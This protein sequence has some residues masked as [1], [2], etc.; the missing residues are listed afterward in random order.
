MRRLIRNFI[1]QCS[2]LEQ[3][4]ELFPFAEMNI[5]AWWAKIVAVGSYR[6]IILSPRKDYGQAFGTETCIIRP[7][8][9][10]NYVA[11]F[12]HLEWT[13]EEI[14]SLH[15]SAVLSQGSVIILLFSP[16]FL[17]AFINGRTKY[18]QHLFN[19]IHSA[20]INIFLTDKICNMPSRNRA[21][22]SLTKIGNAI[23]RK[24]T[25]FFGLSMQT[26]M[27]GQYELSN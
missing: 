21:Q 10:I 19:R 18:F 14:S 5:F 23:K 17:R 16:H 8:L 6:R 26:E 22:H 9:Q 13:H 25:D 15:V 20:N 3:C 7:S 24:L 4:S 11:D 12:F 2:L 27:K 1:F